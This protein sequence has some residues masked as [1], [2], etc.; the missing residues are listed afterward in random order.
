MYKLSLLGA[1]K[2]RVANICRTKKVPT[3]ST[4]VC[5]LYVLCLLAR[6]LVG[7]EPVTVGA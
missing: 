5:I 2:I 7:S 1:R 6:V 4:I 3:A